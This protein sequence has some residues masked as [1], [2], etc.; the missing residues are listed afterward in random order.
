MIKGE[1][2]FPSACVWVN[3]S[4]EETSTSGRSSVSVW[5]VADVVDVICICSISNRTCVPVRK[6]VDVVVCIFSISYRIPVPVWLAIPVTDIKTITK[7]ST[8]A[9]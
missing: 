5:S 4:I 3:T 9:I 2:E 8:P 6:G 7:G 1:T